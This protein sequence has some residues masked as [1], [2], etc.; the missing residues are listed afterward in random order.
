MLIF[1][2]AFRNHIV[3]H[4]PVGILHCDLHCTGFLHVGFREKLPCPAPKICFPSGK[5]QTAPY[6]KFIFKLNLYIFKLKLY[7]FRLQLHNFRVKI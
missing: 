6:L 4:Q 3:R 2:Y 5:K 7:R 1:C